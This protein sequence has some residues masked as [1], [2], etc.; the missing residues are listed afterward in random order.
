MTF[1][2]SM[3]RVL[4]A[5]LALAI[6]P[7]WYHPQVFVG[8]QSVSPVE[9]LIRWQAMSVTGLALWPLPNHWSAQVQVIRPLDAA[10]P[11]LLRVAADVR[12]W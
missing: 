6:M 1:S 11:W 4:V 8:V 5:T 9:P 10:Q 2:P 12:V 7:Q 3:S